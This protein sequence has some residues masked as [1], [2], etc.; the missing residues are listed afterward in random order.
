MVSK[1]N[2][3][4]VKNNVPDCRKS[5]S[6]LNPIGADTGPSLMPVHV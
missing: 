1:F 4:A 6:A 2:N 3:Y 5:R